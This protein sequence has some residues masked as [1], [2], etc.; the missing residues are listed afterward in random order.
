VDTAVVTFVPGVGVECGDEDWQESD[1]QR[2]G[3]TK[4]LHL[5]LPAR[6]G[7][8]FGEVW[9]AVWRDFDLSTAHMGMTPFGF[10][11]P[12]DANPHKNHPPLN[13]SQNLC[14]GDA[15]GPLQTSRRHRTPSTRFTSQN[16][17]KTQ[18]EALTQRWYLMP[19]WNPSGGRMRG[20][21]AR[22]LVEVHWEPS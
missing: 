10:A 21:Q 1:K 12:P 9:Q 11:T 16:D 7:L 19:A 15:P 18:R 5:R 20:L 13:N 17:T 6:Q 22:K 2:H 4:P 3:N 8:V 14:D